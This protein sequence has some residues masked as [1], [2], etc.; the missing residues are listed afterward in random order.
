MPWWLVKRVWA[1]F[2]A[3]CPHP[4]DQV[5][6]DV[7]EGDAVWRHDHSDYRVYYCTRCGA[8]KRHVEK[9]FRLPHPEWRPR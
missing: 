7:L 1:W 4:A 6:Y 3:R 8:I 5:V 9:E 2:I